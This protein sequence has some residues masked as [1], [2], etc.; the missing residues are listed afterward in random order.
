MPT[1]LT[2]RF[3]LIVSVLLAC[4]YILFP[5]GFR[6][7]FKPNIR[8]GIDMVGGSSLLYQVKTP[9]N[10]PA[11]EGLAD[12]VIESLRQRVDPKGVKNLVWRAQGANQTVSVT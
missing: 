12:R 3:L 9:D 1:N 7:D 8:P 11:K 2:G 6:G 4:P 10:A 5:Y